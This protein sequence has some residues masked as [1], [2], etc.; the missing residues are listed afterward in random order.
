MPQF[1]LTLREAKNYSV[2]TGKKRLKIKINELGIEI[3]F[4][5][6]EVYFADISSLN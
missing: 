4:G 2:K 6:V 1:S 5:N 3:K